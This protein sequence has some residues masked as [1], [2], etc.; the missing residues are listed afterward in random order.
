MSVRDTGFSYHSSHR[1]QETRMFHRMS[2]GILTAILWLLAGSWHGSTLA[3][4]NAARTQGGK[5]DAADPFQVPDGSIEVL[6]KYIDGLSKLHPS[7]SLPQAV[8][9]LHRKRAAAQ[10]AACEKILSAQPKPDQGQA[11]AAVRAKVA[12]LKVLGRLGDASAQES[13]EGTVGQVEKLGFP[14]M[15]REVQLAA[16]DNRC[17]KAASLRDEEYEKL[18]DR[19]KEFLADGVDGGSAALAVNLAMAAEASN[20]PTLAIKAYTTLGTLLTASNDAKIAGSAASMLGAARRLELVGKPFTLQGATVANKPVDWKKYRGKVVLIDF[21]ATWCG[22]CREE[23]PGIVNCYKTYHKRGFEVIAISL[24]RDRKAIEDYVDKER[25]PWTILLDRNEARG[26]DKSMATYYGIFTIPQMI[27]VGKDGKVV[28]LDARGDRLRKKL[29]ELLGPAE[30]KKA[31]AAPG[32]GRSQPRNRNGVH[33]RIPLESTWQATWDAS[34]EEF[35]VAVET[36]RGADY[37]L[38]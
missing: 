16:L 30:T 24:D 25:L 27:L 14:E 29:E 3:D 15:V 22:P 20:R 5:P 21:F 7:S 17:E 31:D 12:A 6:Q 9:E 33:V 1:K 8:V 28:A 26:T 37:W 36:S 34:P 35:R 38:K 23:V 19:L 11:Q 32:S 2:G 4:D 18:V 13:L 10:L